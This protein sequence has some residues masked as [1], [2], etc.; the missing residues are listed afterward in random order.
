MGLA[1]K[2]AKES[3]VNG[4]VKR[5]PAPKPIEETQTQQP[6]EPEPLG[7]HNAPG[8]T[9]ARNAFLEDEGGAPI[10]PQAAEGKTDEGGT[11]SIPA[12]SIEQI[13][14]IAVEVI[15]IGGTM[16]GNKVLKRPDVD[17]KLETNEK[18]TVEKALNPVM[19][20]LLADSKVTPMT[21][22]IGVLFGCYA[23]RVMY[24]AA[25][26]PPKPETPIEQPK[27]PDAPPAQPPPQPA[28]ADG[29]K[30]HGW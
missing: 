5:L 29:K 18:Q 30:T 14:S 12:M 25:T 21:L 3:V 8:N 22:F 19:T 20:E 15:D 7:A 24:M 2:R 10:E 13:C 4:E 27:P 26:K 11:E 23:P 9:E 16:V 17:W 6:A 28:N 1:K